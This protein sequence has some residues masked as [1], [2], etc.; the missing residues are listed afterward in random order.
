MIKIPRRPKKSKFEK[1]FEDIC[2]EIES[3]YNRIKDIKYKLVYG[4]KSLILW[5]KAIWKDRNWDYYYLFEILRFKLNLML[6][7]F[8]KEYGCRD[9]IRDY[10]R[11]DVKFFI[12]WMDEKRYK[13]N[14]YITRKVLKSIK[15][16]LY[17]LDV[18]R[19]LEDYSI[20]NVDDKLIEL[21]E[22]DK[23]KFG[24]FVCVPVEING[25]EY[26]KFKREF[27]TE[28]NEEECRK[29]TFKILDR[30]NEIRTN[31][32]EV[33]QLMFDRDNILH[34]WS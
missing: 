12:K 29:L 28:E 7:L 27:E 2:D 23:R 13:N 33:L 6:K 30:E 9:Y 31:C 18:L 1:L 24:D 22:E 17:A 14:D 5:F 19:M 10:F 3:Y 26:F 20:E 8:K 25:K 11:K 15:T 32:L 34:W 4:I 16:Y 21:Y